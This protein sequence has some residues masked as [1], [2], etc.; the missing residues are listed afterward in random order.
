MTSKMTHKGYS[1]RIEYDERDDIFT[2]RVLGIA[3]VIGFHADNVQDLRAAFA[4]AIEHY[5]QTCQE[6]GTAPQMPASGR[7]M[8]RMTPEIHR[9]SLNAAAAS[10]QSLNQWAAA[11]LARAAAHA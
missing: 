8:L 9:A 6:R 3:D 2:G 4:E 7:V 11:A 5:I 1:A 10:G